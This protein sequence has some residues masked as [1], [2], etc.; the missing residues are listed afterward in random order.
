MRSSNTPLLQKARQFLPWLDRWFQQDWRAWLYLAVSM[1][2]FLIMS[3]ATHQD[4]GLF[5]G[6]LVNALG[7]LA[8]GEALDAV[9]D[10]FT[11]FDSVSTLPDSIYTGLRISSRCVAL[12][13]GYFPMLLQFSYI[14]AACQRFIPRNDPKTR[15]LTFLASCFVQSL[16]LLSWQPPMTWDLYIHRLLL[17]V[18]PALGLAILGAALVYDLVLTSRDMKAEAE[19]RRQKPDLPKKTP[20]E[21]WKEDN[22]RSAKSIAVPYSII[23]VIFMEFATA[24]STVMVLLAASA[25]I[26]LIL[27]LFGVPV[28]PSHMARFAPLAY[29]LLTRLPGAPMDRF[30]GWMLPKMDMEGI[31]DRSLDIASLI[32]GVFCFVS[33]VAC[34]VLQFSL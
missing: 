19:A 8:G 25:L 4:R 12:V 3:L 10:V 13:A 18:A 22:A 31:T 5:S 7:E 34:F 27:Q 29:L 24:V 16:V 2:L 1:I 21:R 28:Q 14:D 23:I 30:V 6:F 15:V 20:R 9:D 17:P 26:G 33:M 11:L 32:L